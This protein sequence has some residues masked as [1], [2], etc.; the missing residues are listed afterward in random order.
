MDTP[1][2]DLVTVEVGLAKS[3]AG[4]AAVDLPTGHVGSAA[5]ASSVV[6]RKCLG[7]IIVGRRA[8][9]RRHRSRLQGARST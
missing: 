9:S 5:D 3:T 7:N 2:P 1:D 8:R 4:G 6:P